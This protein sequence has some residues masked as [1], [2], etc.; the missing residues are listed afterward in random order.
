M[1]RASLVV[2]LAVS[3]LPAQQQNQPDAPVL[4]QPGTPAAAALVD[5]AI[6]KLRAFGRGRF[7]SSES[8][9][10][11]VT[12]GAGF[13]DGGDVVVDGGWHRELIW[14]EHEQ[15]RFLRRG[16]RL[17]VRV[18]DAWR[19]RSKKLGSGRDAPFT[20]DPDLLCT[21]LQELPATA[22]AV[23]HVTAERVGDRRAAVLSL[24]LT[25][26]SGRAFVDSG[27][28]P[29]VGNGIGALFVV[30]GGPRREV[31]TMPCT[32]HLALSIDPDNGDLLRFAAKVYAKTGQNG[33]VQRVGRAG[34]GDEAQVEPEVT[35]EP[36]WRHGLPT[37]KPER[38]ESVLLY[39]VEFSKHGLA[40]PPAIDDVA[41]RLLRLG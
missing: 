21:V 23:D 11:A 29:E 17:V 9:D 34:G 8:H 19:L 37:R 1:R 36:E 38:D 26:D 7:R 28:V 27:A 3:R 32:V 30:I 16:G 25:E 18:E 4:P 33:F 22:R 15:D 31:P 5:T 12:R 24:T 2:L 14:G 35:P 39:T 10:A 20:L 6:A 13:P 41:R 40:E